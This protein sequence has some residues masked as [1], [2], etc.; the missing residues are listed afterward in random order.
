MISTMV[1]PVVQEIFSSALDH[2]LKMF[3]N[4]RTFSVLL[5]FRFRGFGGM[6]FRPHSNFN[7]KNSKCQ[8]TCIRLI[9][10]KEADLTRPRPLIFGFLLSR[11]LFGLKD[12]LRGGVKDRRRG[13]KDRR[14]RVGV[15]DRRRGGLRERR[16]FFVSQTRHFAN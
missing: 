7:V 8:T 11:K 15:K 13:L 5:R 6:R 4:L 3:K 16:R 10:F 9:E 1:F 12:R 2:D 14:R